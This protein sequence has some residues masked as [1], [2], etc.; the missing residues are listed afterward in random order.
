MAHIFVSVLQHIPF[1]MDSFHIWQKWSLISEA[2]SYAITVYLGICP[3]YNLAMMVQQKRLKYRTSCP[4]HSVTS[5]VLNG[6]LSY[7]PQMITSMR[8]VGHNDFDLDLYL[9]GHSAITLQNIL[10]KYF[11]SC[12]VQSITSAV[13]DGL[14]SYLAQ[15]S[16]AWEDVSM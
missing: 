7:V 4:V 9:W 15:W 12:R 6:L 8:C 16:A 13:L 11:S 5:A 3:H 2:M 14:L 1:L 10:W